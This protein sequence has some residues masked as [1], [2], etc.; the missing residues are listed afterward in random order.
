MTKYKKIAIIGFGKEGQAVLEYFKDKVEQ[1]DIYDQLV[2]ELELPKNI[3]TYK[4]LDLQQNYDQIFKSPGISF[5]KITHLGSPINSTELQFNSLTNLL[6]E[7]INKKQLIAVTGTKG[8]S[9]TASLIKHIL[10]KNGQKAELLGNIGNINLDILYQTEG[11]QFYVFE[12]SSFQSEFLQ[13]SPHIAV[14]TSFYLDHQDVHANVGEYLNAKLNL[15]N[16]QD[17][18]DLVLFSEQFAQVMKVN[19]LK[20]PIQAKIV[21]AKHIFKTKLLGQHNQINCQ[22]AM[23]TCLTLGITEDKILAAIETYQPL[24]GR[25][26]FIGNFKDINFYADDLATIPEASWSAINSFNP[27]LL[28]TII[29]GGH[30]K[31]LDYTDLANKLTRTRIKNFI[32]F[33]PTGSKITIE[34]DRAKVNVMTAKSMYKAVEL[35]YKLTGQNKICLM[36]CASASFGLFKNAYDRGNQFREEVKSQSTK[37]DEEK[38]NNSK[39]TFKPKP[40][41]KFKPRR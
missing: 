31:G 28:E 24:E 10:T 29:I 13:H 26:E 18:T 4:H 9:T 1:I 27:D 12:V 5:H 38:S 2:I 39:T 30:D 21:K 32:C 25:L 33:E 22:L 19:K 15:I 37:V 36:S 16:K 34:L 6:F 35:A 41:K 14:F 40:K 11:N 8:K 23:E 20:L 7:K 17:S 3:T